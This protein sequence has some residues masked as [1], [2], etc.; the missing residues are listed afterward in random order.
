MLEPCLP[1]ED[2]FRTC[3]L[4]SRPIRL[5]P[6]VSHHRT[7]VTSDITRIAYGCRL[8]HRK[9]TEQGR[10]QQL[11]RWRWQILTAVARPS[12][13]V[14]FTLPP[15]ASSIR[16]DSGCATVGSPPPFLNGSKP[17]MPRGMSTAATVTANQIHHRLCICQACAHLSQDKSGPV[18]RLQLRGRGTSASLQSMPLKMMRNLMSHYADGGPLRACLSLHVCDEGWIVEKPSFAVVA[19]FCRRV[20]NI[21]GTCVKSARREPGRVEDFINYGLGGAVGP[22]MADITRHRLPKVGKVAPLCGPGLGGRKTLSTS[23]TVQI[24]VGATLGVLC[25][26]VRC[27]AVGTTLG[28]LTLK[29]DGAENQR[30]CGRQNKR[31]EFHRNAYLPFWTGSCSPSGQ[32]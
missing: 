21:G 20:G 2:V 3:N 15:F 10:T 11:W 18:V 6:S 24:G 8:N 7:R 19:D 4:C 27:A 5:R 9:R 26:G 12:S 28:L 30:E 22:E 13:P 23:P 16:A 14:A 31:K 1:Q 25:A 29:M 17:L 32:D